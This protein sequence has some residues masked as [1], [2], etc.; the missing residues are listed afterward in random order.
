MMK[1]FLVVFVSAQFVGC[2]HMAKGL[3]GSSRAG[4][5]LEELH[6]SQV[7]LVLGPESQPLASLTDHYVEVRGLRGF[8]MLRVQEWWVLEGPH[9]LPVWVGPVEVLGAR[10]G[11]R[12]HSSGAFYLL[13]NGAKEL[14]NEGGN[15]VVVEGY[16]DGPHEIHVMFHRLLDPTL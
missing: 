6:G 13:G 5:V 8:G 15:W 7:R 9:A 16:V 10:V 11:L 2:A 14:L 3:V 1:G 12:D 4:V